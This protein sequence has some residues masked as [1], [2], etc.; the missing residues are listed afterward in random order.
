ME[1]PGAKVEKLTAILP[2]KLF[3]FH[4]FAVRKMGPFKNQI[5]LPKIGS[6][7]CCSGRV[8]GASSDPRDEGYISY[9]IVIL[10]ID[11]IIK[12]Q[13]GVPRTYVWAPWY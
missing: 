9:H 6:R 11:P 5:W 4:L 13:L 3:V 1:E 10:T 2:L 12:G 8:S 7:A